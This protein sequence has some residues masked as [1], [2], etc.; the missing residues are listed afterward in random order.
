MRAS[1]VITRKGNVVAGLESH[2][3]KLAIQVAAGMLAAGEVLHEEADKLIPMDT[4]ALAMSGGVR[5]E[6]DGFNREV[7]VFYGKKGF[8]VTAIS[9][10]EGGRIVHRV[11]ADYAVRVHQ[12]VGGSPEGMRYP[13]ISPG[14]SMFLE[15]PRMSKHAEMIQALNNLVKR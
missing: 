11:P 12:G 4:A 3:R 10:H 15:T 9:R 14:V 6:G 5:H 8:E 2:A 7:I 13:P 1:V